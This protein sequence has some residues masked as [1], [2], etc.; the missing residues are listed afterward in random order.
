M[1]ATMNGNP[2]FHT[3]YEITEGSRHH[4]Q[5]LSHMYGQQQ[6]TL[7]EGHEGTVSVKVKF[8]PESPL[9]HKLHCVHVLCGANCHLPISNLVA[10]QS[11]YGTT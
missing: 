8:Y 11:K 10:K 4:S 5:Q 6:Q 3:R 9:H 7:F 2:Q 1:T